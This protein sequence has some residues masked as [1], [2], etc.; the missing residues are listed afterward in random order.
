MET[1]QYT[2]DAL[3]ALG[4]TCTD[5]QANFLLART[6]AMDGETLYRKLKDRG[7]LVRHFSD[8]LITDWVRITI[9]SQEQMETLVA[10]VKELVR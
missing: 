9:G 10:V 2:R 7:I 1:R 4:F 8:P 6:D 3:T 5:S